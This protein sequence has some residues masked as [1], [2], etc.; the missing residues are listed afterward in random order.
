VKRWRG[1]LLHAFVRDGRPVL[2]PL[3]GARLPS[4]W[5]PGK[6]GRP[7]PGVRPLRL[8]ML[9]MRGD[10]V[11]GSGTQR[12]SIR[13]V[14]SRA[15]GGCAETSCASDTS[16]TTRAGPGMRRPDRA[17]GRVPV[18][19]RWNGARTRGRRAVQRVAPGAAPL[20]LWI[21]R[22]AGLGRPR[23]ADGVR[24]R[25]RA[26]TS[27]PGDAGGRARLRRARPSGRSRCG[28][29]RS[30]GI[31]ATAVVAHLASCRPA[32]AASVGNAGAMIDW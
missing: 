25:R 12:R 16:C 18:A 15:T 13:K 9:R 5:S 19:N 31:R 30:G 8:E 28:F 22:R 27:P 4:W 21:I 20:G 11:T 17:G 23:V 6:G 32:L 24:A 26:A 2:Y 7:M 1:R 10:D 3:A 29:G 14:S